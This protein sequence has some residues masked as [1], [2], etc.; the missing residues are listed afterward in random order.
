MVFMQYKTFPDGSRQELDIKIIDV[1]VGLERIPWLVNGSPTSYLDVFGASL[2]YLQSK[3]KVDMNTE[4]WQK[5]GPYSCLLN[6]DEVENIESTWQ[7]V[8]DRTGVSVEEMK[9]AIM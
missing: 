5:L 4:V 1:G 8:S 9:K 7:T 3:V 2:E 6:I